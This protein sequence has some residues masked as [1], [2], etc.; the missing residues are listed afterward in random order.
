MSEELQNMMYSCEEIYCMIDTLEDNYRKLINIDKDRKHK[1]EKFITNI[2]SD[3]IE[4]KLLL[5][6]CEELYG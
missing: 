6:E 2:L 1:I 3:A 5:Q 4:L